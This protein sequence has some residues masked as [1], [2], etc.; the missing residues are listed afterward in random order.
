MGHLVNSKVDIYTALADRLHKNP[1]GNPVNE[2]LIELLYRIY[3]EG[4]AVI[5]SKFPFG[6][7]TLEEIA[8]V[9]GIDQD[10]LQRS[11]NTM[12]TKGL[13][14]VLKRNERT[15][16]W[17]SPMVIGFYEFL[18]MRVRN[19]LDLKEIAHLFDRY[20]QHFE[21]GIELFGGETKFMRTLIYEKVIP[22]IVDTEVMDYDRA[23]EVIKS[24]GGGAIGLCA[25]RHK[26]IHLNDPCKINAPLDVCISLGEMGS[27]AVEHFDAKPAT[28]DELLAVLEKSEDLGL[29]HLCDNVL[30]KPAFICN[31]CGCCCGVLHVTREFGFKT[32]HPSSFFASVNEE[33]CNG[34][35]ECVEKCQVRAI[36]MTESSDGTRVAV[37]DLQ[38]CLGC[39]ICSDSCAFE[40]LEMLRRQEIYK[41]V[42]NKNEL[43]MQFARER[44][45]QLEL[46]PSIQLF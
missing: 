8:A 10:K 40:A 37:I 2:D 19:D 38:R 15:Y 27:Y 21:V 20:F 6:P 22:A 28:V 11:L 23:V 4:E 26:A 24:S 36:S 30:H 41:P 33:L 31:C 16:Y 17:L 34:C 13:V 44:G 25:C 45:K 39:G 32:A 3:S 14:V 35:A 1:V 43:Y 42:Q 18:F 46:D 29:V 7:A 5:G 12:I 9:A